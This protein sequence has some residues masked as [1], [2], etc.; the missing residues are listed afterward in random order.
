M[1]FSYKRVDLSRLYVHL[2]KP[3]GRAGK[4]DPPARADVLQAGKPTHDVK[5][6]KYTKPLLRFVI[7][8]ACS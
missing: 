5:S 4:D 3:A 2:Y 7:G 1:Q 6:G 8:P